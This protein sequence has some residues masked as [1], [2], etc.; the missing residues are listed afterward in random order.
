MRYLVVSAFVTLATLCL[1]VIPVDAGVLIGRP[2]QVPSGYLYLTAYEVHDRVLDMI[3]SGDLDADQVT[4]ATTGIVLS[5]TPHGLLIEAGVIHEF[6]VDRFDKVLRFD[7]PA[8]AQIVP[9]SWETEWQAAYY[10]GTP[11]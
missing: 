1:T 11:P 5:G 8:W 7:D 6:Y 9:E 3:E 4:I 10:W 2:G